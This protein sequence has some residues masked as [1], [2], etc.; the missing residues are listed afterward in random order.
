MQQELFLMQFNT[1]K[2]VYVMASYKEKHTVGVFV[3]KRWNNFSNF[4][5][6]LF[7]LNY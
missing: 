2:N 5:T 1:K 7:A 4:K 3:S 6:K